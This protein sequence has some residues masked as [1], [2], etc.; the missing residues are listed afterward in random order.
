MCC[1]L[2][3]LEFWDI[4]LSQAAPLESVMETKDLKMVG[5]KELYMVVLWFRF[6]TEKKHHG[7]N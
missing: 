3:I 1:F 4:L 7:P 6:Y 5:I 2:E